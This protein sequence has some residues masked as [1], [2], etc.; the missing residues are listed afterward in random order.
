MSNKKL[1][2]F[3]IIAMVLWGGS[4]TSAK[5]ISVSAPSESVIFWRFIIT[6]LSMIPLVFI[7]KVSL[8]VSLREILLLALGGFI[9]FLYNIGFIYGVK[10]GFAGAGG[11]LVTGL[12][13]VFTFLLTIILLREKA[14]LKQI[15]I[16]ALGLAGGLVMLKIWNASSSQI[17]D[18]GNIFFLLASTSWA[19]V[20]IL[21]HK[22]QRKI[23]FITY[24]FYV[25]GFCAI[26]GLIFSV[27][28]NALF[29]IPAEMPYWLNILY[30]SLGATT[31]ATTIYFLCTKQL[32][33]R[34]ASSFIF[35]VPVSAVFF[36]WLLL[37]EVPQ[38]PTIIGGTL[39]I[40]A[41]YLLNREKLKR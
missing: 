1:I 36:S 41:V 30:L 19:F 21:S 24:S 7:F 22:I 8:K 6:T 38:L 33:S 28:N 31:I 35:T 9:M 17:L 12:N 10:N 18:G 37:G 15:L 14:S 23:H 2:F 13:P 26:Y 27:A 16:L 20:T 4:W 25:F 34:V 32:G 5:L 11:V 39:T 3:L 40:V 29:P